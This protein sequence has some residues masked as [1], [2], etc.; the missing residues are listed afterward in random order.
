MTFLFWAVIGLLT[1]WQAGKRIGG[2]GYG[3]LMDGAMGIAGGMIGGF[4]ASASGWS[5]SQMWIVP[6]VGAILGATV[7]TG[8]VGFA[9]GV[10]RHA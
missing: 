8:F 10:R 2:Y 4:A 5:Y 6:V 9:S 1:G 3:P 7:A